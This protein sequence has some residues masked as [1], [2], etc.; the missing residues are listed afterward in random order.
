M[1]AKLKTAAQVA[2]GPPLETT[3]LRD[4]LAAFLN[5]QVADPHSGGTRRLGSF[6]FGVYAFYDYDDE[7]IYVGQ[8]NEQIGTRVR[9]HLTNQ[10]TDA[11][12]MKVLDPFEVFKIKV[13]TLPHHQ[14]KDKSDAAAKAELNWLESAVFQL[15]LKKSKFKAV[16]NE[17][18][19]PTIRSSKYS[20][21]EVECGQ[22]V[23]KKVHELRSHPD[24][25][26]ARRAETLSLL[27][28]VISE[29]Q[30]QKG[31]RS[32]LLTQARR[33]AWLAEVRLKAVESQAQVPE[34]PD[35]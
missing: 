16:L 34:D 4:S 35:E 28:K 21:P 12:A 9:R 26:L 15:L 32:T 3:E 11:V 10:R 20:L 29:R 8:T 33:L 5:R 19:P 7:P 14:N 23:S 22:I 18:A 1:N 13:W 31:L 17:K 24:T 6:K 27:A 2:A 30:V 25:R